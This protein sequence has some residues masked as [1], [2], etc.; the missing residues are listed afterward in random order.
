MG[1][2]SKTFKAGDIIEGYSTC[3]RFRVTAVGEQRMLIVPEGETKETVTMIYSP[4]ANWRHIK[5]EL[6]TR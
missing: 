2:L 1:F 4:Q 5:N 3:I 6:E